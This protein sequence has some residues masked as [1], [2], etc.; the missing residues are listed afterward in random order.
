MTSVRDFGARGDGKT[1]D[2][3]AL[4][5]AL[6]R[7]DGLVVFPRGDYLISRSLHVP[8]QVHG[9]LALAG[10]GGTARLLMTGPGP[11]L[12]LVGSHRRNA[13]PANVAEGV[14]QR[15]RLPT[16]SDLE[17][18]GS[19]PEADGIRLDGVMQPTL[20]GLLIRRCRHGIHLANRAR[21]VLIHD[22]HIYDNSGVGVFLDRVNLHQTNINSCHISYCK[23]G[24]IKIVGS[25]IR[26]IQ[27]CGNDIE[28]NYDL[29]ADASADVLFD[30]RNGTVR[31]GTLVGNTIQAVQSPGGA[32]VRFLGA[33]RDNPNAVGLFAITGNLIGSQ[34]TALHLVACRGVAVSGNSIYSGY[35]YALH[36]EDAEHL[37]IGA[38]SVDHNPEYRGRSTDR[39]ALERCRNVTLTGLILQHTREATAE[40]PSSMEVRDCRNVS[41]TGCQVINARGVGIAVHGSS[42]VRVADCTI[43]GREGDKGYRAAVTVDK[44]SERVMVV[45]N[46][47]GAGRAG[48]FQLPKRQGMASG[49]VTI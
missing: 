33:G 34:H 30:C 26:N 6:Q 36:A 1:D 13:L 49:N 15:E 10:S 41:L 5:H 11:A 35:H 23:Q 16:V 25:E 46:F 29:K 22:C 44:A 27:I 42:V 2:T 3:A 32:N 18:I 43:R 28:Y 12:H 20:R 39:L 17:I 9:R 48:K 47:L 40:V 24:G 38:N 7:G 21:N 37:V 14:W 8:L 4:S 31:E 19:H 45:N